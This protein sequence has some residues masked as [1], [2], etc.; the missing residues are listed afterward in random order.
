MNLYQVD[1]S[2]LTQSEQF[3]L[4][5][6][7]RAYA[8]HTPAPTRKFLKREENGYF[9]NINTIQE[10]KEQTKTLDVMYFNFLETVTRDDKGNICDSPE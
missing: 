3:K 7:R 5:E 10:I 2:T 9:S 8:P 4:A 6:F 1:L